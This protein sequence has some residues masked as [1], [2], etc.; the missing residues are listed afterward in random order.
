MT[1]KTKDIIFWT[2]FVLTA[3]A[4]LI[5]IIS[6]TIDKSTPEK[7]EEAD[8]Y[9]IWAGIIS[10]ISLVWFFVIAMIAQF[11]KK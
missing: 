2:P 4:V 11:E 9:I 7:K 5:I 1:E 3:I 6:F 8:K 10:T